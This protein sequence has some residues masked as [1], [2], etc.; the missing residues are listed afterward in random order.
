MKKFSILLITLILTFSS[1]KAFA[2]LLPEAQIKREISKQIVTKYKKYTNAQLQVDVLTI[3]TTEINVPAGKVTYDVTTSA[4][5]F[6]PRDLV[7]VKVLVNGNVQRVFN[8]PIL[9]KA[10]QDVL[11]A[12]EVIPREKLLTNTN[13]VIERREVS[14][15]FSNVLTTKELSKGLYTKKYFAKGE[16]LDARYVKAKPDILRN[17]PVVVF[18]NTN[19]LTVS[20]DGIALSDGVIGDRITV[21]N[22]NYNK[23]Y[24]GEIIGENK[25]LV[26]I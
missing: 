13:V 3:P 15:I 20:I 8:A 25:V 9:V 1:L 14:N 24:K 18:F 17:S 2:V 4:D 19:N 23:V 22:K 21:M 26:R 11:V 10:Y 5:K 6:M 12:G 7:K 16:L